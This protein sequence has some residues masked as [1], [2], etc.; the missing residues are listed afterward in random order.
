VKT[1]VKLKGPRI[2]DCGSLS[3]LFL[4]VCGWSPPPE[5]LEE[6]YKRRTEKQQIYVTMVIG[7]S[8]WQSVAE[9]MR[10]HYNTVKNTVRETMG[11]MQKDILQMPRYDGGRPKGRGYGKVKE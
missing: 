6:A 4:R 11:Y 5:A 7:A 8:S 3:A 1:V 2:E 9:T 10:V